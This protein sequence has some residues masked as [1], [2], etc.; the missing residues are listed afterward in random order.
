MSYKTI[1][2]HL[3]DKRRVE[4]LLEP[5]ID[6]STRFNAH[7]IGL[8]VSAGDSDVAQ[9]LGRVTNRLIQHSADAETTLARATTIMASFVRREANVLSIID[10][11]QV[12]FWAAIVGLL[13]VSLMRAAPAG[14][15]TP[16][17][18]K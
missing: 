3:S 9:V 1:L 8:H 5:A 17:Q 7:L 6:L 14:P 4:R 12:A 16:A 11:F 10:G 18:V 15:L 2:V 13:L